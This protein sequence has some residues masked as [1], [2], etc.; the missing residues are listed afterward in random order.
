MMRARRRRDVLF[1]DIR[2]RPVLVEY[3]LRISG[4]LRSLLGGRMWLAAVGTVTQRMGTAM[5]RELVQGSR[6]TSI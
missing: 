6:F 2:R 4:S 3:R 5:R 1:L